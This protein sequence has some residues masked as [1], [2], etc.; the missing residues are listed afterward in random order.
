MALSLWTRAQLQ[1]RVFADLGEQD[2][3]DNELLTA[4]QVQD[5]LYLGEVQFFTD[6]R[7]KRR[8]ATMTAVDN[9]AEYVMPEDAIK[10]R[11]LTYDDDDAPLLETDEAHIAHDDPGYKQEA[12]GTPDYWYMSKAQ[13]FSLYPPPDVT[14]ETMSIDLHCVP[15]SIGGAVDGIARTSSVVTVTTTAAHN[16]RV[17]DSITISGSSESVY[18]AAWTVATVPTSV[19]FTFANATGGTVTVD[20]YA[21]YTGG[22]LP[23]L[24]AG[25]VPSLAVKYRPAVAFF[26]E[27]W[28]SQM[29][30]S[31]NPLAVAAG[32][33][34]LG[35]FM[36]LVKQYRGESAL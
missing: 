31:R 8:T 9:Q 28:I 26:A 6:A 18:N 21:Y 19:T 1:A 27:W 36:L 23:M 12:S 7:A 25:D 20:C 35:N 14:D 5:A 2:A 17:G 24:A 22:C 11:H 10:I 13:S 32:E 29:Q 3:A 33:K 4:V 34:A 15:F 16:L 30:L